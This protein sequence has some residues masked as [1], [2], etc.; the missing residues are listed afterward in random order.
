M[1][2]ITAVAYRIDKLLKERKMSQ[3]RLEKISAVSH[4]TLKSIMKERNESVN[5]K[6][7]M[8]IANGL[9]IS[10]ME[11]FNDKVFQDESIEIY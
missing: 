8:Q 6:T 5:L 11:F 7:L 2:I 9:D 1:K 10:I 3:Y 4:N